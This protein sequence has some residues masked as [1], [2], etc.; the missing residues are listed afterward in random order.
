MTILD[1]WKD[2]MAIRDPCV[3]LDLSTG[4]AEPAF[5]AMR[6]FYRMIRMIGTLVLRKSYL[7]WISTGKHL[8]YVLSNIIVDKVRALLAKT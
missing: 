3:C 4:V 1:I 8:F 5:T 7:F 6:Y 2:L